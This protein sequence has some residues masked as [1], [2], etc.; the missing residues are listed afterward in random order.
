MFVKVWSRCAVVGVCVLAA[1]TGCSRDPNVRKQKYLESGERY[2]DKGQ[3]R[4][5]AIQ[6]QNAIQVD[7]N[8]AEAHYRLGQ[9]AIKL[10][11]WPAAAQEFEKAVQANPEHAEARLGLANVFL[12][13]STQ[14][15]DAKEQLDWLQKNQPQNPDVFLALAKYYDATKNITGALDAL[16]TAQGL[17]KN[18][19]DV[20]LAMGI[21]DAEAQQ[22]GEADSDLSKAVNLDPK[23]VEALIKRGNLRQIRGQ[24]ADADQDYRRAIEVAPHDP[25]PRRSLANLLLAE[26]KP[27]Y[28]EDFLRASKKDFP[29]DSTGYCLLGN[30]YIATNQI[31]KALA[32]FG[33]LY[34]EHP[35]DLIVKKNYIQLL[36][37]H[38]RLDEAAKLNDELLKAQPG[39]E[40]TAVY[41]GEIQIRSGKSSD[42]ADTLQ[43]LLRNDPD[44]AVAHYQLGIAFDQMGNG[45][46][47]EAEWQAAVRLQP[48]LIEAHGALARAAI[49]RNDASALAQE[50]EQII[51]LQPTAPDGY[52]LRGMA[53]LNRKQYAPAEH[54]LN[55]AIQRAPNNPAPYIQMGNLKR[56]L[57]QL[58]DAQKAYQQAL[59]L[60]PNSTDALGGVVNVDIMQKQSE[61]GIA[62]IRE[63]VAKYPNNSGFHVM[64]GDQLQ[65][66]KKD[67]TGAEAEYKR[68][69][70]LNKN[71]VA[72]VLK[73]GLVQKARGQDDM[74]LQTFLDAAQNNPKQATFYVLAGGIYMARQDWERSRQMYQKALAIQPDDPVASNN[75]AYVMLQQGGNVDVAFEMAKTARRQLPDNPSSADTLGWAF[76]KKNVYGSAIELFQEA[77][78]K[79]PQNAVYNYHLGMA[80]AKNGQAALARQQLDR[81]SRIKPNSSEAEDLRRALAQLRG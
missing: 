52:L 39:D 62:R 53:E 13:H 38:D 68:A 21:I 60:D 7:Q 37:M 35:K 20:Y 80:Y 54:Y 64:L 65:S 4:E 15:V 66:E 55:Q 74:A 51:S 59:N 3:Y 67:L 43:N 63:Q 75:M 49:Q 58:A 40:D 18:R 77:V 11:Q 9:T 42:A 26:N 41:K 70:E 16:K 56:Q 31:D 23:S 12:D 1:L 34:Q 78:K 76:Y 36:V 24:F 73:L 81:V 45:N 17:D 69:I 29:N 79:E 48:D 8:F 71:N 22:W 30:Y 28:V 25:N 47:A 5:A 72:A 33:S 57:N 32:E 14:Y 19:A 6:Y 10:Q 61:R 46:R 27:Q 44:N 50:A 2:Y